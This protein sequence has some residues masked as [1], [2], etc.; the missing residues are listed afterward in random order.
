MEDYTVTTLL[1]NIY[2]NYSFKI[3]RKEAVF[4]CW[5]HC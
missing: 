2:K 3:E 5:K 1:D 4:I